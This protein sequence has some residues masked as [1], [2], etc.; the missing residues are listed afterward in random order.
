MPGAV[1]ARRRGIEHR[2]WYRDLLSFGSWLRKSGK[3][4]R[5]LRAFGALLSVYA[6]A[7][8][9]QSLLAIIQGIDIQVVMEG[10]LLI[11]FASRVS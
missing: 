6:G 11:S 10:S 7:C 1:K 4:E 5:R 3:S 2:L 9:E 8:L